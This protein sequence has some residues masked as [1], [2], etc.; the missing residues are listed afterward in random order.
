MVTTAIVGVAHIHTPGF[1][2]ML[3]ERDDVRVKA[4]YE[5][6][7]QERGE[8]TAKELGA[9]F[10]QN[11]DDILND[12][13]ITSVVICSETVYHSE[14]VEQCAAAGKD[15]FVEKPLATTVEDAARIRAAVEKAGVKFQTGFFM[16]SNGAVQFAKAEVAAGHLGK[17][18]RMRHTNCHSAAINNWF[19]PDWEWIPDKALAGGGGFADLG[20]HSLDIIL[21][22]LRPVCG[23]VS[24]VAASLGSGFVRYKDTD[25]FGTGLITFESGA[26]AVIEASW[27]DPQMSS[28]I[29]INGTEGQIQIVGDKVFYYSKHVDGADGGEVKTLPENAPHAFQLFFDA[30]NGH[31]LAVPLVTIEEAAEEARVMAEMYQAAGK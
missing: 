27:V 20:A 6:T 5:R 22:I 31:E 8:N 19:H 29:E 23:Q 9:T 10:T 25:E 2:N 11:L 28:P 7:Q 13:E 16:R 24:K 15:L 26:T 17:I 1:V 30:L 21:M 12:P 14:L 18:T 3:K 4:V